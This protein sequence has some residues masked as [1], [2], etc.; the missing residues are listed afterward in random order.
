MG[1]S[2]LL[3]SGGLDSTRVALHLRNEDIDFVSLFLDLG[4]TASTAE[5]A[6]VRAVCAALDVRFDVISMPGFRRAFTSSDFALFSSVPN[7]GRHV[8]P[9][10]SL[11]LL[12]TAAPYALRNGAST[13]YVGYNSDD[14]AFSSEYSQ[15]FLDGYGNLVAEALGQPT[16]T[17][18]APL[19]QKGF[20]LRADKGETDILAMTYSC[21]H[22]GP[23]P[24]GSCASCTRRAAKLKVRK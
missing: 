21:I 10:G 20:S 11:V 17:F 9:L 19:L 4:Q 15:R 2:I 12:G 14:S 8:L 22:A 3:H 5:L 6:A 7:P 24:C 23:A 16:V 18:V 13:V 1:K